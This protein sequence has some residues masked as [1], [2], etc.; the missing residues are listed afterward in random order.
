M[1]GRI[2]LLGL[3]TA[4]TTVFVALGVLLWWFS[5]RPPAEMIGV[6]Q[7]QILQGLALAIGLVMLAMATFYGLPKLSEH[8]VRAQADNFTFLENPL[9]LW[10][11]VWISLGAG[12][13]EEALFRGGVQ[14][15]AGDYLGAPLAILIGAS[16]FAI[17]HF[18]KPLVAA[19]I[20]AI[21]ALFG[22]VYWATDSL[23]AVMIGHALYD[24]FALWYVQKEMHRLG[25]FDRKSEDDGA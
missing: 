8:L 25:V 15:L 22:V 5:G 3:L 14:T 13:G 10:A 11:I 23:L 2:A 4:Q 18:A 21:G 16:L 6:D 24:V 19:I 17:V 12:I 9:P 7:R 20:F 1:P